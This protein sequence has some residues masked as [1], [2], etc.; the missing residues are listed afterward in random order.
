M[1]PEPTKEEV[2]H[3]HAEY[4]KAVQTI[5][6]TYKDQFGYGDRVLEVC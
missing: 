2:A 6:D 4:I 5:F 3:Y 1:I